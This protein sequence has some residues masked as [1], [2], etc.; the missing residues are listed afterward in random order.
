MPLFSAVVAWRGHNPRRHQRQQ[1]RKGA[2]WGIAL[3]VKTIL[4]AHTIRKTRRQ[5]RVLIR[6]LYSA[7]LIGQK[8]TH[9]VQVVS[10]GG[11]GNELRIAGNLRRSVSIGIAGGKRLSILRGVYH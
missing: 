11:K 9:V 6:R 4:L 7:V 1:R 5:V 2:Q 3:N 8:V 10:I